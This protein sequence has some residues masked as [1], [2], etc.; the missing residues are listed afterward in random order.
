MK[1]LFLHALALSASV[2][3]QTL[4]LG[5]TAFTA[6]G[7]FP[8]SVYK[9]YYN[10]PTQTSEQVQPV[11]TDPV[12]VSILPFLLPPQ[13]IDQPSVMLGDDLSV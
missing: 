4:K 2:C 10:N 13:K 1:P 6:P 7:S 11:I 9:H 12:L 3:A 5:P 8:T